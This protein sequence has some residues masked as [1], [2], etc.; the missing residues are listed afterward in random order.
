MMNKPYSESCEQNK[1]VILAVLEEQLKRSQSVLEIGSGTGQ[2]AVYFAKKMPYVIWHT[3]DCEP[4]IPG[5]T[6]W[7]TEAR[8]KNTPLP[9]KLDVNES[10]W[11][12]CPVDA[13]FTA[14][15]I[16]IMSWNSVKSLFAGVGNLLSSGA[17]FIVYGPFNYNGEYTS[18]SNARFD[19]WLKSRD[20][21]SCIKH[22]EDVC[23]LAEKE[24]MFLIKDV[25][26][27]ANNR[28]LIWEKV[29]S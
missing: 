19:V 11:P 9:V 29:N 5:I 18:E 8:L 20:P 15:S 23:T 1:D 16:H 27:P 28:I 10:V 14:N 24:K 6:M 2:H 13:V 7:L 4:Y 26:M 21:V 12:E 22:F 17:R 3:S 25:A